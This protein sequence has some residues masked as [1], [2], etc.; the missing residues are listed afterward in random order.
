MSYDLTCVTFDLES[1]ILKTVWYPE[2]YMQQRFAEGF[3]GAL[4]TNIDKSAIKD[5]R[6][7][8]SEDANRL[9]WRQPGEFQS[10]QLKR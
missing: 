10:S 2:G 8:P 9:K 3:G 4:L 6:S 7:N 5:G 1:M